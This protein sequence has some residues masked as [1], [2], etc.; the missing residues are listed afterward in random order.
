VSRYFFPT[1]YIHIYIFIY[2][3]IYKSLFRRF[4]LVVRSLR[5]LEIE[6]TLSSNSKR[7]YLLKNVPTFKSY[8]LQKHVLDSIHRFV[9]P[10]PLIFDYYA[11]IP[12]PDY[13]AFELLKPAKTIT[14]SGKRSSLPHAVILKKFLTFSSPLI[15]NGT[16]IYTD[17]SKNENAPLGAAVFSLKLKL[18]IKHKLPPDT[19]IFSAEAWAMYQALILLKSSQ[20]TN[21]VIF[22]DSRSVLDALSSCSKIL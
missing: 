2:I 17:D 14:S 21:A 19:S 7:I 1:L 5:C 12:T 8:I 16:S 9:F 10:S 13:H 15:A 6:S 22:C 20:S 11:S 3:Y 18:A 4:S